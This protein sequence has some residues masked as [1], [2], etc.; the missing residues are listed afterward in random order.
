MGFLKLKYILIVV[1]LLNFVIC[2]LPCGDNENVKDNCQECNVEGSE[3]NLFNNT[4]MCTQHYYIDENQV[5]CKPCFIYGDKCIESCP[6]GTTENKDYYICENGK[7]EKLQNNDQTHIVIIGAII[8]V[9]QLLLSLSLYNYLYT[10]LKQS[11][12]RDSKVVH[13]LSPEERQYLQGQGV[14]ER[15]ALDYSQDVISKGKL[16]Q[17][18]SSDLIE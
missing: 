10:K 8:I 4:C 9:V 2:Y 7:D 17:S 5:S 15:F 6:E 13:E 1:L 14:E 3:L 11:F 18:Q 12:I 16:L